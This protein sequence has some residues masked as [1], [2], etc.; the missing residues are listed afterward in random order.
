MSSS[1][2][3]IGNCA[4]K[5]YSIEEDLLSLNK[6]K[7]EKEEKRRKGREGK[8]RKVLLRYYQELS[9]LQL[10]PSRSPLWQKEL[11]FPAHADTT[12]PRPNLASVCYREQSMAFVLNLLSVSYYDRF[13]TAEGGKESPEQHHEAYNYGSS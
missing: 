10:R 3:C 4:R 5:I 1:K 8:E 9:F 12:D 7:K 13:P 6:R 11:L 2:G